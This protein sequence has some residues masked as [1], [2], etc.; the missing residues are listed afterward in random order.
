MGFEVCLLVFGGLKLTV[1]VSGL[2]AGP[3][4]GYHRLVAKV[5]GH[6]AESICLP[7]HRLISGQLSMCDLV[8]PNVA[9]GCSFVEACGQPA[10]QSDNTDFFLR[11]PR[12]LGGL[13]LPDHCRLAH[14]SPLRCQEGNEGVLI[15]SW[16]NF[17]RECYF[18]ELFPRIDLKVSGH[19]LKALLLTISRK[20]CSDCHHVLWQIFGFIDFYV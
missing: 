14:P 2:P 11:T 19:V 6:P 8:F 10:V 3:N 16:S 7:L 13:C 15:R 20:F 9:S 5:E 12:G 17:M 18:L 1:A 4:Q